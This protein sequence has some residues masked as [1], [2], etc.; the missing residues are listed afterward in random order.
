MCLKKYMKKVLGQAFFVNIKKK[1][2]QKNTRQIILHLVLRQKPNHHQ[3]ISA[4]TNFSN[5]KYIIIIKFI[6]MWHFHI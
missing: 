6:T 3:K 1:Y 5:I 2:K 4:L